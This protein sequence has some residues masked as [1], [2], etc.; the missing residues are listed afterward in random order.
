MQ[1]GFILILSLV[2]QLNSNR[3]QAGSDEDGQHLGETKI[4]IWNR[5]EILKF[6]SQI[7]SNLQRKNVMLLLLLR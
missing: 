4:S 6:V 3:I 7:I 5:E 1:F 2:A